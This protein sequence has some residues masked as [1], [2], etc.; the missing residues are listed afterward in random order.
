[1]LYNLK[2]YNFYLSAIPQSSWE[3]KKKQYLS[4]NKK[5]WIGPL[6]L[7][8]NHLAQMQLLSN[9][10]TQ[11][12]RIH[13]V[14][15]PYRRKLEPAERCLARLLRGVAWGSELGL[16]AMKRVKAEWTLLHHVHLESFSESGGLNGSGLG[17]TGGRQRR[18]PK[19]SY[20]HFNPSL[21]PMVNFS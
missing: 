6:V 1:M 20:T 21:S 19:P 11:M 18:C 7:Y 12:Q 3:K 17:G 4:Q 14:W 2:V 16:G 13:W 15:T 8:G 9:L 10:Q 5:A